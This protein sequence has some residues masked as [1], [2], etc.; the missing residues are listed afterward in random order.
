MTAMVDKA[1]A[2]KDMEYLI[3]H[4]V[5]RPGATYQDMWPFKLEIFLPLLD[6][7]KEKSDAGELWVTDHISYHQ[8]ETERDQAKVDVV[9]AS[10]RQIRLKLTTGADPELYD[11]P[12]TLLTQ[13]PG[14]W[15]KVKVTHGDQ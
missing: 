9:E 2:S 13:V 5:E 15:Q 8:Y 10:P 4:G 14:T 12:L 3:A 7:M 6:Y 11:Y 1:I